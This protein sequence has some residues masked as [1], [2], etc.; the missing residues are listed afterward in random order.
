MNAGL[1]KFVHDYFT[2]I[3]FLCSSNLK[4]VKWINC[5]STKSVVFFPTS[6]GRYVVSGSHDGSVLVW[7]STTPPVTDTVMCDPVIHPKLRFQAHFDTVNGIRYD[8]DVEC[9][10]KYYRKR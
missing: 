2:V 8:G 3:S 6:N 1:V 10:E 5:A 4:F 9:W 7:D